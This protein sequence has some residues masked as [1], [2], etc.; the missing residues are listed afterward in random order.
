MK[1]FPQPPVQKSLDTEL[2]LTST[3]QSQ[4][5]CNPISVQPLINSS[6]PIPGMMFSHPTFPTTEMTRLIS[7]LKPSFPKPLLA[8]WEEE[9]L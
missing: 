4:S 6:Q 1:L 5:F 3:S 8:I 2:V 7:L 9:L